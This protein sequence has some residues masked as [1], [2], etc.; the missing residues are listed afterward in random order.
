LATEALG[1]NPSIWLSS[2]FKRMVEATAGRGGVEALCQFLDQIDFIPELQ[3]IRQRIKMNSIFYEAAIMKCH[4]ELLKRPLSIRT[5]EVFEFLGFRCGKC[6]SETT[7]WAA[8]ELDDRCPRCD[9]D[10]SPLYADLLF[11][12]VEWKIIATPEALAMHAAYGKIAQAYCDAYGALRLVMDKTA[13][14]L[15]WPDFR[16]E[17]PELRSYMDQYFLGRLA[18]EQKIPREEKEMLQFLTRGNLAGIPPKEAEELICTGMEVVEWGYLYEVLGVAGAHGRYAEALTRYNVLYDRL[19]ERIRTTLVGLHAEAKRR[20]THFKPTLTGRYTPC[21]LM[22]KRFWET[23]QV[24]AEVVLEPLHRLPLFPKADYGPLQAIYGPRGA[25]KTF[26]L[27]GITSYAVL[28]KREMVFCPLSDKSNSYA[29]ACTP[30]FP[31]SKRTEKLVRTLHDVLGVDPQPLPTITVTVLR[32]GEKVDD[33]EQHPPTV[34]DRVVRVENPRG[35]DLDF[36]V[37]AE[38][39]EEVAE[40]QGFKGPAGLINIRNLDRHYIAENVNI[41]VQ[42][43]SNLLTVFDRWRKSHLSIPARVVLDEVSYLA[44]ST[45]ALYSGDAFRSGAT[46]SDF[47]KESRRNRLSLEMAT[48]LPLEVVPDIRNA[49]TNVFFRELAMSKDKN[50]SQIDFLLESL[51]LADPLV[52]GVVREL[53]NRAL[54]GKGYWFW[55]NQPSRSIEVVRPCPPTFCLQDPRLTPRKLFRLYERKTGEK[56]LLDSWKDVKNLESKTMKTE[57]MPRIE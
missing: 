54:L 23:G 35:F 7:I 15:G 46:I 49:A 10:L 45:I 52:R 17:Q 53:N 55:Y 13:E 24:A 25:G 42:V 26:L 38:E 51:Q 33:L 9:G 28:E 16:V 39:L 32:A 57:A 50:R 22:P 2:L 31:Y 37:L 8:S 36:G 6:G 1:F 47:I 20:I 14:L 19:N 48:Q 41:D 27:S 34:Y 56:I 30:L 5:E 44:A 3:P 12:L 21:L 4:K 43:T 11:E 18:G 29:H 40:G